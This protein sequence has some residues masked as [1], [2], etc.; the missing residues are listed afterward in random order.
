MCDVESY[1][2][3]PMLEELGYVPTQRYAFGEEIRL[4]L[5]SIAD[6]F[7]LDADALFH[8]GV[9]PRGMGRGR[10]ALARADRSRRRVHRRATTCSPPGSST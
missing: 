7:D 8:T 5:Q 10:G 4:H 6:K 9:D 1:I 3:M 2:Y